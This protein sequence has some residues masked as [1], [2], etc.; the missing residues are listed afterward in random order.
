MAPASFSP[1][2]FSPFPPLLP[3]SLCEPWREGGKEKIYNKHW[4]SFEMFF[5]FFVPTIL[6]IYFFTFQSGAH[7]G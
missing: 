7:L 2:T 6:F 5:F 4:D 1:H 3:C